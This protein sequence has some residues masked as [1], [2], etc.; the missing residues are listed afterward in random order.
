MV[1]EDASLLAAFD[2]YVAILRFA[3]EIPEASSVSDE[4]IIEKLFDFEPENPHSRLN[5]GKA[6][7]LGNFVVGGVNETFDDVHHSSVIKIDTDL[8]VYTLI[9]AVTCA[10]SLCFSPDG[11]TLYFADTPN[12]QILAYDYSPDMTSLGEPK[13]VFTG[14]GRYA[15][16]DGSTVDSEGYIWNAVWGGNAVI[17]IDPETGSIV[18]VI[19]VPATNTS[20]VAIGGEK[21]D[22]LYITSSKQGLSETE[23]ENEPQ[24]GGLFSFSLS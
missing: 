24:N 11:K 7:Q 14:E 23:L 16:P 10:N 13:V 22:T 3:S 9:E 6:D 8:T 18:R 19:E 5:D 2:S 4:V 21:L 1:R 12:H 15:L 17:R 20:C